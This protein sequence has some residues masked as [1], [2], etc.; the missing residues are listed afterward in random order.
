MRKLAAD[1]MQI[2][3]PLSLFKTDTKRLYFIARDLRSSF[4]FLSLIIAHSLIK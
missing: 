2:L 3:S 4:L 1:I